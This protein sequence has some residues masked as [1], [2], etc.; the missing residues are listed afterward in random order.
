MKK[1][2]FMLTCVMGLAISLLVGCGDSTSNVDIQTEISAEQ[3]DST[4]NQSEIQEI[5]E[6]MVAGPIEEESAY[7]VIDNVKVDI[8]AT[9]EEFKEIMN[10]NGW[11][12]AEEDNPDNNGYGGEV[13]FPN[14]KVEVCFTKT[15]DKTAYEIS[16]IRVKDAEINSPEVVSICGVNP[17]TS[18]EELKEKLFVLRESDTGIVFTLDKYVNLSIIKD[19]GNG[20][21]QITLDR[22]NEFYRAEYPYPED[23]DHRK[24][25]WR[26]STLFNGCYEDAEDYA[27][28]GSEFYNQTFEEILQMA[29]DLG[30]D[31]DIDQFFQYNTFKGVT[32]EQIQYL[33]DNGYEFNQVVDMVIEQ[34]KIYVVDLDIWN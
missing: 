1:R 29:E 30:D 20:D 14:G 21:C 17:M 32:I 28:A 10:K 34:G 23:Y 7:V 24:Y 22:K 4:E 3:K 9:W 27:N 31:F 18:V 13:T 33:Y 25:S 12:M 11:T 5:V 19:Q 15:L 6:P 16:T 8:E 2:F 26:Q